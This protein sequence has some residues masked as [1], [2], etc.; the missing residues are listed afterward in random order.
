MLVQVVTT[1]TRRDKHSFMLMKEEVITLVNNTQQED[2]REILK[3]VGYTD[4]ATAT[5]GTG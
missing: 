1:I 5:F 4:L 2:N 3:Q